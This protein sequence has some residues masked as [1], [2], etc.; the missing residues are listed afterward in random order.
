MMFVCV[1]IYVYTK[2]GM[3]LAESIFIVCMCMGLGLSTLYWLNNKEAHL[4]KKQSPFPE[5]ISWCS[6][7][8]K[9]MTLMIS[10]LS[11]LACLFILLLFRCCLYGDF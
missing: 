3:Q 2:I 11:R 10:L 8:S 4:W 7:L 9:S 1:S 5:A 6:S